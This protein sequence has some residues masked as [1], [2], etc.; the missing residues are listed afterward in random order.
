M[1]PGTPLQQA[2]LRQHLPPSPY[3]RGPGAPSTTSSCSP[4]D[5]LFCAPAPAG[6]A[7]SDSGPV[8][9]VAPS[10]VQVCG[11]TARQ[12][13]GQAG[14]I[15]CTLHCNKGYRVKPK[16]PSPGKRAPL[17]IET[18]DLEG[19]KAGE[20][21]SKS[22]PPASATPTTTRCRAPTLKA[23]SRRSSATKARASWSMS[24]PGV[25]TLK[26]GDH[27]IPLYTP[28]VPP[29]QVLPV[30]QDQPVPADP[31][32]PGQGLMPDATSRFSLDGK[33]SITTWAPRRSRT[34]PCCRDRRWPR[35]ARTRRSTRSATSAAASP[36]ASAR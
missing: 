6:R 4:A 9:R 2:S 17:T 36:P 31:R 22:R 24:A 23:S 5:A 29:V 21:L 7:L 20:V 16:P 14:R 19:P 18:V 33:R 13:D 1:P 27:V 26:K 15:H 3:Q 25:T 35:S 11:G 34:S 32:H 8:A 30:A 10:G 28:G 12:F